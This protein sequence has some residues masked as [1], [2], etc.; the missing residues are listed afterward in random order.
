[1]DQPQDPV[2]VSP[3]PD[4]DQDAALVSQ[5]RDGSPE[6][7]GALYWRH[8]SALLRTAYALTLTVED[9]EEVVQDVFVGLRR[10]LDAYEERGQL[11]SWL[12]RITAR[13]ALDILRERGRMDQATNDGRLMAQPVSAEGIAVRD[14]LATLPADL[15][16][17]VVLRE[18]EGYSHAEIADL[19]GIR[20]GTSEVRLHRALKRLRQSLEE[21]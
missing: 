7:L 9:A 21:R 13:R 15:R 20:R 5:L 11:L 12:K 1:M 14:A 4:D 2:T 6:A 10:A 19:L 17:V 3:V 18:I 16:T 8:A